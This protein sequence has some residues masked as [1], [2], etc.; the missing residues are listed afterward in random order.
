MTMKGVE[1]I[2]CLALFNNISSSSL[3]FLLELN[4]N[5][6]SIFV[7]ERELVLQPIIFLQFHLFGLTTS[8]S[9]TALFIVIGILHLEKQ[10]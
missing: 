10:L 3:L 6:I 7:W 2:T 8:K 4:T 1:N 9:N 5:P